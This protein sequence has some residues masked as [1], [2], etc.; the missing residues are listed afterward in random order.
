MNK[1]N[2]NRKMMLFLVNQPTFTFLTRTRSH[3]SQ[4]K[5]SRPLE[6]LNQENSMS[7]VQLKLPLLPSQLLLESQLQETSFPTSVS[8]NCHQVS[9]NKT[10]Q[11]SLK[12]KRRK[13]GELTQ[14]KV[15]GKSQKSMKVSV[16]TT[17]DLSNKNLPG[18][19]RMLSENSKKD[20]D[21]Q[22]RI[23]CSVLFP[24]DHRVK[25]ETPQ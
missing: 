14:I 22:L 13:S 1:S 6:L 16:Y 11:A 3:S 8:Q 10:F 18:R 9:I 4:R 2:K 19:W 21:K 17:M 25:E 12:K 15:I 23:S 5:P 24:K 7:Q 20:K